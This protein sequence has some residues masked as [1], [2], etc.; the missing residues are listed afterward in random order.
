ML[1]KIT[2]GTEVYPAAYEFHRTEVKG[3]LKVT[4]RD[5]KQLTE[6]S[7]KEVYPGPKTSGL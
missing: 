7:K 5:H 1:F 4:Y 6:R 2:N 3:C